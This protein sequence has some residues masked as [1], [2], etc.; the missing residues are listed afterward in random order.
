MHTAPPGALA[1]HYSDRSR[2]SP[3]PSP[4]LWLCRDGGVHITTPLAPARQHSNTERVCVGTERQ[5]SDRR[6][7]LLSTPTPTGRAGEIVRT[8]ISAVQ[9]AR[10]TFTCQGWG[11]YR[12]QP[13]GLPPSHMYSYTQE[14]AHEAGRAN[15]RRRGKPGAARTP[16]YRLRRP[17][18]L[19]ISLDH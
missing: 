19:R 9:V 1:I 5:P 8:L 17:Q 16:L 12:M 15:G 11:C 2:P 18:L 13:S 6:G 4:P 10:Q 14:M 7:P 3:P